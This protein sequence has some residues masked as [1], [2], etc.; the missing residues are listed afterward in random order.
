MR[1][2][3]FLSLLALSIG[4]FDFKEIAF[5]NVIVVIQSQKTSLASRRATN[6]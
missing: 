5:L 4:K 3:T 1:K 6:F 2:V